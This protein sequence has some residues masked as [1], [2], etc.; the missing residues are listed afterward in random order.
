MGRSV[1]G[2]KQRHS[3]I[4]RTVASCC[5]PIPPLPGTR[6]EEVKGGDEGRRFPHIGPPPRDLTGIGLHD[7]LLPS[8]AREPWRG[9]LAITQ[10]SQQFF[11]CRDQ[12]AGAP[13]RPRSLD[14]VRRQCLCGCGDVRA[15]DVF[16]PA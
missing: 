10:L 6:A 11:P 15:K 5:E 4:K 16:E 7:A 8:P 3:L 14:H 13:A 1:N 12:F 2:Q 9:I